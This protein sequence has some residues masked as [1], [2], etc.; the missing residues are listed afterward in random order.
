MYCDNTAA[1]AI[2]NNKRNR[3]RNK[4]VELKFLCLRERVQDGQVSVERIS[5]LDML[6]DPLT[7]G[8]KTD[9]FVTHVPHMGLRPT[10]D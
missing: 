4:F 10:F 2:A 6:A 9:I 8:L 7:K 1:V 5:T 3:S